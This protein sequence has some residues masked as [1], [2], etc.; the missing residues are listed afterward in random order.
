MVV[1]VFEALRIYMAQGRNLR[2]LGLIILAS[3]SVMVVLTYSSDWFGVPSLNPWMRNALLLAAPI[4]FAISVTLILTWFQAERFERSVKSY[5]GEVEVERITLDVKRRI[6]ADLPERRKK[7]WY[8]FELKRALR[9]AYYRKAEREGLERIKRSL[10]LRPGEEVIEMLRVYSPSSPGYLMLIVILMAAS[11]ALLNP[12][13]GFMMVLTAF[14]FMAFMP[15]GS[16][17]NLYVL[18]NKRIIKRTVASSMFYRGIRRGDEIK[19]SSLTKLDVKRRK[20]KLSVI[21]KDGTD[22]LTLDKI[23][24]GQGERFVSLIQRVLEERRKSKELE[25][26][27]Y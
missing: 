11:I 6:P 2:N 20:S 17:L 27:R 21:V 22:T 8:V 26:G 15:T 19:V 4:L 10:K 16:M 13:L 9:E 24:I 18:T 14:I 12:S 23:P 5:L 25:A 3:T 7:A 1:E